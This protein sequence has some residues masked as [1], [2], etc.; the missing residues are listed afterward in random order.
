MS[1]ARNIRLRVFASLS[2][3]S[4]SVVISGCAVT[5]AGSASPTPDSAPHPV[6]WVTDPESDS[7][8]MISVT[9]VMD[10]SFQVGEDFPS[11]IFLSDGSR[12]NSVC[13]WRRLSTGPDGTKTSVGFGSSAG[14]QFVVI[15]PTDDVFETKS[16]MPWRLVK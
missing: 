1:S 10:G 6:E 12:P 11:G 3:A 7:T 15:Q 5:T 14:P 4:I 8:K 13:T 16:C 2:A 9:I